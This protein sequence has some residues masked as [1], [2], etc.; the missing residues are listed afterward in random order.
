MN[1]SGKHA[2]M[3]ATCVVNGWP[4]ESYRAPE[5]PLQV[6]IGEALEDSAGERVGAVAVDGCGA[7][8]MAISLAGLARAFGRFATSAPETL[9]GRVAGAA[10]AHPEY[11]S[12][13][14]RDEA[15]LMRATPGLLCKGGAEGVYA[16]G[17]ADGRGV[18]V[19]ISDG[20]P[21]ARS[22]V[23]VNLLHR[24]GLDNDTIRQQLEFPVLGAGHPVGAVRAVPLP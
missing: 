22:V 7:P 1:C 9:E 20:A 2:A 5:H 13:S 10:R 21:R 3:L 14:H 12:G 6:V 4:T 18:A 24:L 23:L 19:K 17:L 8:L 15:A 16:A 11:V